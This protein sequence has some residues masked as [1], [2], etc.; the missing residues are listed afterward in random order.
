MCTTFYDLSAL[1]GCWSSVSFR[2]II[3]KF[4]GVCPF[5]KTAV[6]VSGKNERS[7]TRWVAV[8][9]PTDRPKSVQNFCVIKVSDGVFVLSH[10]FL[11]FSVGEGAFI[12]GLSQ[13]SSLFS[14]IQKMGTFVYWCD[15]NTVYVEIFAVY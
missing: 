5:N 3:N 14:Y 1:V 10:Y 6:V 13:I 8:I 2:R 9:T 4:L 7:K 15:N 11:D 12:I